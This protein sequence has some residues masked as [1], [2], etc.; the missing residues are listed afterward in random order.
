MYRAPD[1][2]QV[3]G[4]RL[5]EGAYGRDMYGL[6]HSVLPAPLASA[7]G[8]ETVDDFCA[9]RDAE[10]RGIQRFMP[11]EELDAILQDGDILVMTAPEDVGA[12]M[13]DPDPMKR[14]NCLK[15]RGWHAEIVYK[16]GDGRY[17]QK[18]PW[19]SH[20]VKHPCSEMASHP[21]GSDFIVSIYRPE[22]GVDPIRQAGLKAE[23]R[24][25]VEIF[26]DHKFPE[27]ADQF[28]IHEY[29][30]PADFETPEDL[31][32]IAVFL[33]RKELEQVQKVTCVQWAYQVLCLALN[34]PLTPRLLK[35]IGAY[36]AYREHWAGQ[37][38]YADDA[39]E[40]L[41][42][43]PFVPYTPA[44]TLQS[45]LNTYAEGVSLLDWVGKGGAL[46]SMLGFDLGVLL[47]RGTDKR[48]EILTGYF[49]EVFAR[50][51]LTVPLVIPNRPP[52]R[53]VMPIQPFCEV[54]KPS[55]PGNL[56]WSYV[57]TAVNGNRLAGA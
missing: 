57:A 51:D 21:A 13:M 19:H 14:A 50:R 29:L 41:G 9:E 20:L 36:E 18:A 35:E 52:Y 38:G 28:N 33:I 25:W 1:I 12:V 3:G 8:R 15:Q 26:K 42:R 49:A 44:E 34:A 23:V 4:W 40:P 16:G 24:R 54:R 45:F 2:V 11:F 43:V 31:R 37:L 32:R 56:K 5:K 47:G 48:A 55:R 53:H 10:G 17:W 6:T 46:A 27:R 30:D 39:L 7:T 22:L